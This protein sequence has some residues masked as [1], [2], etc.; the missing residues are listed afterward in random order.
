[1]TMVQLGF[2]RKDEIDEHTGIGRAL[3]DKV[4][5]LIQVVGEAWSTLTS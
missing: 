3:L 1:M 4:P 2:G 5:V